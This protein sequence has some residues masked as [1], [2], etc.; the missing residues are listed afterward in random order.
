MRGIIYK[1]VWIVLLIVSG[2]GRLAAQIPEEVVNGFKTGNAGALSVYFSQNIE[3]VVLDHDDIFSKAQAQQIL[4]S[5]FNQHEAHGFSLKHQGGKEG[6]R[7]AI[8][9]LITENGTFRVYFLLKEEG[10]KTCIHQLRIEKQ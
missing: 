10:N 6:A 4:A 7:Y 9:S 1:T 5:F 3:M 8:G 2:M